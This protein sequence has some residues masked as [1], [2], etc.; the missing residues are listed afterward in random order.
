MTSTFLRNTNK[1]LYRHILLEK[2]CVRSRSGCNKDCS[3]C[4]CGS[5]LLDRDAA[6][7]KI[8]EILKARDPELYFVNDLEILKEYLENEDQSK[9]AQQEC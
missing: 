6:L 3:H 5:D 4:V 2:E 8:L 1:E 7:G 9:K